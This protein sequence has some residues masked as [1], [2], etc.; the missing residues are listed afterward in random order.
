MKIDNASIE[1][2]Y[3]LVRE[4]MARR[5]DSAN[6]RLNYEKVTY[7]TLF[8]SIFNPDMVYLAIYSELHKFK[9]N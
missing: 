8:H 7:V 9:I 3:L 6:Q 5:L 1:N 4:E 2:D